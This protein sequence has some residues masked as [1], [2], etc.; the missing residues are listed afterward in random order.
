[1]RGR[2]EAPFLVQG[3]LFGGNGSHMA[4]SRPYTYRGQDFSLQRDKKRFVLP[5]LFRGTVRESSGGQ[6]TLC[7]AKHDRWACLIGFGLSRVEEF[8]DLLDR[9]QQLAAQMG[10]DFDY[11]LRSFQLYGFFEIPF[12]GSGRFVLPEHVA[13]IANIDR[14]IYFQ[15][16]GQFFTLWSP[17]ELAK[18]GAGWEAAQ[19]ACANL[20]AKETAKARKA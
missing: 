18:M 4:G 3:A 11:D 2:A 16:A 6:Q 1:M 10:K 5:N 9:E 12:D 15:G 19:A 20:A 17:E 14:Q 13:T 8:P 7:L